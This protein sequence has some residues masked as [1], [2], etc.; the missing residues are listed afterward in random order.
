MNPSKR[1]LEARI[2][3]TEKSTIRFLTNNHLVAIII[4][5]AAIIIAN[6]W[7]Q[8]VISAATNFFNI[9]QNEISFVGWIIIAAIFTL[10]AYF[11]IVHVFKIPITSAF[12]L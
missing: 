1:Q 3:G 9:R 4:F 12:S 11:F 5:V 8:V 10:L 7:T 2:K 6:L